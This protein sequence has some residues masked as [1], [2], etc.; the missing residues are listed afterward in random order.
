MIRSAY[1]A[2]AW[3]DGL[4]LAHKDG[5]LTDGRKLTASQVRTLFVGSYFLSVPFFL[6]SAFGLAYLN[7]RLHGEKF[8]G[9]GDRRNESAK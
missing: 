8:G 7:M 1:G 4:R 2:T 6:G 9:H 5:R 3:D